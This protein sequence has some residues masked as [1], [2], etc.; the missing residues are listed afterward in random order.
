[1]GLRINPNNP[2]LEIQ[3]LTQQT[4]GRLLEGL[5]QQATQ[6]RVNNASDDASGL[7][8][9]QRFETQLRQFNQE[10]NNLQGAVSVTQTA[11]GALATQQAGVQRLNELALQASNG[12]LTD[13]QRQAL[14]AEAQQ[15]VAQIDETAQNTEFNGTQLLD[16]SQTTVNV[17]AGDTQV[18]LNES[19]AAALGL[20]GVDLTTQAGANAALSTTDTAL[21]Q[22][23]QN[24]ASLGAQSNRFERAIESRETQTANTRESQSQIRDLDLAQSVLSQTRNQLLLQGQVN[25]LLNASFSGEAA[26]RLLT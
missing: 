4:T 18:T 5:Q 20:G 3:R 17:G 10:I 22:L 11:D 26:L 13:D 6:Q 14:N 24:R 19:T 15:I 8:I 1:M 2:A 9:V 7:A 12:T 23:D 16:G 25:G 21:R